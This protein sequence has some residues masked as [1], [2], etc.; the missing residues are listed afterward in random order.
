MK[1][2]CPLCGYPHDAE[3]QYLVDATEDN[4]KRKIQAECA[5]RCIELANISPSPNEF[6]IEFCKRVNKE[7]LNDE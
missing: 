7:F 3:H 6:Y 4:Y 2:E 5:K 1:T